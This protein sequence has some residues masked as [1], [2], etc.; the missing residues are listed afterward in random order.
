[1]IKLCVKKYSSVSIHGF[2]V[3]YINKDVHSQNV[4]PSADGLG[5]EN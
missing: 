2:I 5:L 4:C 3:H 1:M